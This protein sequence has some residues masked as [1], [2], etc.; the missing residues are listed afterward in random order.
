MSTN[1]DQEIDDGCKKLEEQHQFDS[2]EETDEKFFRHVRR[3]R[4]STP[5]TQEFASRS[6]E[7]DL[8]TLVCPRM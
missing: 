3:E 2:E 4:E 8:S 1:D 5:V 7:T 6:R